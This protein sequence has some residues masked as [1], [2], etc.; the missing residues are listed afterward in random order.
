VRWPNR[1][2]KGLRP[3]T[4]DADAYLRSLERSSAQAATRWSH[5]PL[6]LVVDEISALTGALDAI[7][8]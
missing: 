3:T 7:N 1:D 5:L 8:V 2:A 4:H 6:T